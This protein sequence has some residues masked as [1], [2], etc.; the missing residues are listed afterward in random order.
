MKND[1]LEGRC[2]KS[3]KLACSCQRCKKVICRL[4]C[5]LI[6]VKVHAGFMTVEDAQKSIT[7]RLYKC[8]QFDTYVP[9]QSRIPFRN[10]IKRAGFNTEEPYLVILDK[11][12]FK[13]V[14][15]QLA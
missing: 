11:I 14:I 5:K 10:L 12:S 1:L 3:R 6:S 8:V 4:V 2:E 15:F 7:G 13:W 9:K